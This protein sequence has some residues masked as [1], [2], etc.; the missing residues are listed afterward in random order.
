M[1]QQEVFMVRNK[2]KKVRTKAPSTNESTVS[3]RTTESQTKKAKATWEIGADGVNPCY[4]ESLP[5]EILDMVIQLLITNPTPTQSRRGLKV[6]RTV[7][8]GFTSP[9]VNKVAQHRLRSVCRNWATIIDATLREVHFDGDRAPGPM[10]Q[11]NKGMPEEE[12]RVS[13][14]IDENDHGIIAGEVRRTR[15]DLERIPAGV[16]VSLTLIK[17]RY[18]ADPEPK[19]STR[20]GAGLMRPGVTDMV[21]A[22]DIRDIATLTIHDDC[23]TAWVQRLLDNEEEE[24]DQWWQEE[25]LAQAIGIMKNFH[26][27]YEKMHASR[28]PKP[29]QTRTQTALAK[30]EDKKVWKKLHTFR[31]M[32]NRNRSPPNPV[33]IK[34]SPHNFPALRCVELHLYQD[35][36]LHLWVLPYSQITHLTIGHDGPSNFI[37]LEILKLARLSLESLTVRAVSEYSKDHEYKYER[38][39]PRIEFPKLQ[40]LRVC[41]RNNQ[42]AFEQF[43]DALTCRNLRTFDIRTEESAY[44]IGSL[45]PAPKFIKRSGCTLRELYIDTEERCSPSD[46]RTLETL[47]RDHSDALEVFHLHGGLFNFDWLDDLTA[48]HLREVDFLCFGINDRKLGSYLG[49]KPRPEAKDF[50]LRL[51]RWIQNWATGGGLDTQDSKSRHSQLAVRFCAAP[52]NLGYYGFY[53]NRTDCQEAMSPPQAVESIQNELVGAGMKVEVEW[54]RVRRPVGEER[55]EGCATCFDEYRDVGGL[56]EDV[57]LGDADL[58]PRSTPHTQLGIEGP[59][60]LASSSEMRHRQL[61]WKAEDRALLDT[62]TNRSPQNPIERMKEYSPRTSEN[63]DRETNEGPHRSNLNTGCIHSSPLHIEYETHSTANTYSTS[64][65]NRQTNEKG[66]SQMDRHAGRK[67]E[68]RQERGDDAEQEMMTWQTENK[69]S[70]IPI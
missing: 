41:A 31:L 49:K 17:P 65:Q 25:D 29:F 19:S 32:F 24:A 54:W 38:Q 15:L 9:P 6:D 61:G 60:S 27:V 30:K 23:D 28:P 8:A 33:F 22:V 46:S 11:W 3:V 20:E 40:V 16:P 52:D 70:N 10:F 47:M 43:L 44:D 56:D 69:F 7:H 34:L 51:F 42:E 39:D 58:R 67:E 64:H 55:F 37:L 26:D 12:I 59:L 48:P 13:A 50:A 36:P 53:G 45:T 21:N 1:G 14:L 2:P 4:I 62:T 57:V 35:E 5:T 66:N 18:D 63:G 68:Q